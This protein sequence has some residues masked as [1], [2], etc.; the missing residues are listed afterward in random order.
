[1]THEELL[2]KLN[3]KYIVFTEP[4]SVFNFYKKQ[5]DA[6]RAVVELH[7]P[8]RTFPPESIISIEVCLQ[9]RD[10]DFMADYPCATIQ[11]IEKELK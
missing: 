4:D 2:E 6:L 7:Q 8:L 1:M 9:C 5:S 10:G 11:A 3:D